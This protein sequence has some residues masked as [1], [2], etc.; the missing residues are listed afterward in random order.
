M[1]HDSFENS[2]HLT[3]ARILADV[4]EKLGV[5]GVPLS[6]TWLAMIIF[7]IVNGVEPNMTKTEVASS[8]SKALVQV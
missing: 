3:A 4:L 8:K 1:F 2:T 5:D 6:Q 7:D